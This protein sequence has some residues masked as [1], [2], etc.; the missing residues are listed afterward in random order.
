MPGVKS[1]KL[2]LTKRRL[3]GFTNTF[4]AKKYHIASQN[5]IW[6]VSKIPVNTKV[7]ENEHFINADIELINIL[8][9]SYFVLMINFLQFSNNFPLLLL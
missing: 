2:V 7:I 4:L 9:A 1:T 6:L 8:T 3:F 5:Y